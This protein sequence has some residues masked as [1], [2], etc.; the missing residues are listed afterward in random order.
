M[1]GR[2]WDASYRDDGPAPWDIGTAQPV[3]IRLAAANAF[4]GAV[5][6]VGCGT[7]EN[8]LHIAALGLSVLGVDV[9]ETAL[10]MARRK[11]RERGIDAEFAIADA[12]HL[13]RLGRSFDTVLDVGLF[14]TF[15][16]DERPRY[17]ASVASA[18]KR[19]GTLYVLCFSDIGA[20]VGPH[21]VSER[22]L[23]AAFDSDDR[24]EVVAIEA[25]R[26]GTRFHDA[27]APA[28]LATVKR[29]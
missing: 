3:V 9:A 23:R 7:G 19:G 14:H 22:E 17:V 21:P 10:E 12:L 24:W 15:D 16:A 18:T 5:L 6:D 11:S 13:E 20:D 27:G 26:V 2:P 29:R 28:W 25:E 1:S 4:G 8:T